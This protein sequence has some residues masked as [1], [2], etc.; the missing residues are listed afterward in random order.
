VKTKSTW[1][2]AIL[3]AGLLW[4][5][6]PAQAAAALELY[7]TFH[8]MGT[9]ATPAES[10]MPAASH[11]YV[12]SPAGG[13]TANMVVSRYNHAF[14]IAQ[15][16]IDVLNLTFRHYG[17]GDYAKAL[18]FDGANDSLSPALTTALWARRPT[19]GRSSFGL[20]VFVYT[21]RWLCEIKQRRGDS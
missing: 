14:Y 17:Q 9:L 16:F 21:Y 19:W 8:A 12:V 6:P 15:D 5:A 1:L 4:P 7:G 11:T 2:L 13:G 10:A 20:T 18:Y 3:A